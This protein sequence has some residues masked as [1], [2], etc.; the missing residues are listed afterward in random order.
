MMMIEGSKECRETDLLLFS[1]EDDDDGFGDD[2]EHQQ[3]QQQDKQQHKLGRAILGSRPQQQRPSLRHY[4]WWQEL[5]ILLLWLPTLLCA[6][7]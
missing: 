3:Q 5:S 7:E 1:E 6:G 4:L 2:G